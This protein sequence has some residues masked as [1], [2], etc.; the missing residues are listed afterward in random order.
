MVS[1]GSGPNPEDQTHH[2]SYYI[3]KK[4]EMKNKSDR[5]HLL[6]SKCKNNQSCL[7]KIYFMTS[8]FSSG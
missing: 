4:T 1:V 6:E 2:G 5:G 8:L 7:E 3:E